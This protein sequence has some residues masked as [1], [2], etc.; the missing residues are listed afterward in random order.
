METP[1]ILNLQKNPD[2]ENGARGISLPHFSLH[3]RT[4]VIKMVWYWHKNRNTDQ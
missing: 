1:K 4:T 2:K 3:Y